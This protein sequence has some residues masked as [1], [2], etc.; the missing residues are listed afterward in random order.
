MLEEKLILEMT[1]VVEQL[2]MLIDYIDSHCPIL[3]KAGNLGKKDCF[4]VNKL[5][6]DKVDV[7]S[8]TK[9]M[10]QYPSIYFW[11]NI[12]KGLNL[13]NEVSLSSTKRVLEKN[14][15]HKIYENMN[16]VEKY[17]VI[18][19]T[20]FNEVEPAQLYGNSAIYIGMIYNKIAETIEDLVHLNIGEDIRVN[21]AEDR[22]YKVPS[23]YECT[24]GTAWK[25]FYSI[26][27][28][29]LCEMEMIENK[30][31]YSHGEKILI[32]SVCPT[33]LSK[34]VLKDISDY[35]CLKIF[36]RKDTPIIEDYREMLEGNDPLSEAISSIL[37]KKGLGKHENVIKPVKNEIRPFTRE[38]EILFQKKISSDGFTTFTRV[39]TEVQ[40]NSSYIFKIELRAEPSVWVR[41]Q[42]DG[43]VT[44][45]QL[46]Y[47]I[48]E[49]IGFDD[50]HLYAFYMDN[51]P[52]SN[53]AYYDPRA[54]EYGER[55]ASET[56]LNTLKLKVNKKFAY[57][58]DFGDEWI[59]TIYCER[60]IEGKTS[61]IIVL[62][63]HGKEIE[64]YPNW[65]DDWK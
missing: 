54:N 24:F 5:M 22:L 26:K 13:Y 61:G 43:Y 39:G 41:M 17:I 58:Y 40:M 14:E 44:L 33:Y 55:S 65:G 2:T 37:G 46:S 25:L 16:V 27:S 10:D 28:L 32:S 4:E 48:L 29:G 63:S 12:L 45:E 3:T 8:P 15:S 49:A 7:T 42:V 11:Y 50:D 23:K 51:K 19:N 64:Q 9:G 31:F 56:Q 21:W 34:I 47:A 18:L 52:W 6:I 30:K 36:L 62:E 53:N 57:L 35:K 60:I 38:L 1:K 20:Y 59:F